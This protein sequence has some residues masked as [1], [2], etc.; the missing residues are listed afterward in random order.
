MGWMPSF[1]YV[2]SAFKDNNKDTFRFMKKKKGAVKG[3]LAKAVDG[4]KPI[5]DVNK[6]TKGL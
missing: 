6:S 4:F 5:A 3:G 2:K 1:G